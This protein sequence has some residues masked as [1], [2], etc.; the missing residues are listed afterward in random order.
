MRCRFPLIVCL[1]SPKHVRMYVSSP[2]LP[3]LPLPPSQAMLADNNCQE[4]FWVGNLKN[5]DLKGQEILS[6]QSTQDSS[7]AVRHA[8]TRTHTHAHT[9][10]HT[11]THTFTEPCT[12]LSVHE[13]CCVWYYGISGSFRAGPLDYIGLL[14]PN[15]SLLCVATIT[16]CVMWSPCCMPTELKAATILSSACMP[17]G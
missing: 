4:A 1:P 10:T 9:H 6:Q 16:S 11:H 2:P 8:H 5:R 14:H 3:S 7:E 13:S 15:K 12:P 17:A